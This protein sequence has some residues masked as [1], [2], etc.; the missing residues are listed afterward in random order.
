VVQTES[1]PVTQVRAEAGSPGRPRRFGPV[2]HQGPTLRYLRLLW[3]TLA[4]PALRPPAAIALGMIALGTVVYRW[5]EGWSLLDAFYFS[6]VT[7]ATVGYGDFSPATAAGKLFTVAY[8]LVGV[9]LLGSF[10]AL[11]AQRTVER[12]RG[13]DAGLAAATPDPTTAPRQN[14]GTKPLATPRRGVEDV[15]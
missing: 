1:E 3:G 4:D 5:V 8:I 14:V 13:E 15:Q 6:V 11:V 10:L 7:L 9:G 2:P 12:L